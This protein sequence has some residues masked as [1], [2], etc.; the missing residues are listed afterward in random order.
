MEAPQSWDLLTASLCVCDLAQPRA[1]WAFLVVQGLVRDLPQDRD[2]FY[3]VVSEE[4]ERGPIT[5]LSIPRRIADTLALEGLTLPPS[6]APDPNAKTAKE[7]LELIESWNHTPESHARPA[8]EDV[9]RRDLVEASRPSAIRPTQL[10][11]IYCIFCGGPDTDEQRDGVC[12]YCA[13]RLPESQSATRGKTCP[14]CA[15]LNLLIAVF[16]QVCGQRLEKLTCQQCGEEIGAGGTFCTN[17]GLQVAGHVTAA[18]VAS[19]TTPVTLSTSRLFRLFAQPSDNV[20]LTQQ[21]KDLRAVLLSAIQ[22]IAVLK[23]ALLEQALWDAEQYKRLRLRQMIADQSSAGASPWLAY[24]Y[25]PY[26]L[27]DEQFLRLYLHADEAAVEEFKR[28]VE[29]TKELT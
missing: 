8:G 22:D 24:S 14:H 17:C 16:C 4:R 29:R 2:I 7:R 3:R 1:V 23:D 21:V 9:T 10:P 25:Y 15:E 26:T 11:P 6:A 13:R 19:Q 5:G 12:P 27:E 28:E 20:Q 18:L